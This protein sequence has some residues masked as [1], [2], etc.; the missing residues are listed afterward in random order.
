M[1]HDVFISYA[2]EDKEALVAP[3]ARLLSECGVSVWYDEFSLK[4]GDSL[5]RSID[6]GL[7]GSRYGIVI[8]SKY[9]MSKPWPEYEL[10]G[11]ISKELG[12]ENVILPLWYGVTREQVLAFSPPLADKK[13]IAT[14][15]RALEHTALELLNV[16]R[17]DL[18]EGLIRLKVAQELLDR[19]TAGRSRRSEFHPGPIRHETLPDDQLVR[20]ALIYR[21]LDGLVPGPITRF[22]E[23]FK[24]DLRPEREIRIW[25]RIANAYLAFTQGGRRRSR[26]KARVVF[27]ALLHISMGEAR[28]QYSHLSNE[29]VLELVRAFGN[30]V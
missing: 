18:F 12:S 25:E 8:I 20:L 4:V 15:G 19:G 16:I 29:E 1:A 7:S 11:L 17:P 23:P 21:T 28:P 14:A 9:F 5:S 27:L 22:I 30:P 24:R 3:L 6:K 2:S 10:R 13:A 26:G